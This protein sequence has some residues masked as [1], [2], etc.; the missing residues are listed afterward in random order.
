MRNHRCPHQEQGVIIILSFIHYQTSIDNYKYAFFPRTVP[1]WNNLP[2]R[3][4]SI[5]TH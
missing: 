5:V 1:D 4:V 2:A 3:I